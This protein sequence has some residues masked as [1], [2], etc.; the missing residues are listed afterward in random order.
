MILDLMINDFEVKNISQ[1]RTGC[2]SRI[3]S[4]SAG[5]TIAEGVLLIY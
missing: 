3:V 1:G 2:E 5:V 4:I